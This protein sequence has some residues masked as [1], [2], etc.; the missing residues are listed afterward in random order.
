M[1]VK[2][3]GVQVLSTQG[4]GAG[5]VSGVAV[6]FATF[7]GRQGL[8]KPT[9]LTQKLPVSTSLCPVG[10]SYL[11]SINAT[12]M[13]NR[14]E[15]GFTTI[16][17]DTIPYAEEYDLSFIESYLFLSYLFIPFIG[18]LISVCVGVIVSLLSGEWQIQLKRKFITF[19]NLCL[20]PLYRGVESSAPCGKIYN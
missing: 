16:Q 8:G 19:S 2:Y 12:S 3:S 4:A 6:S 14:N 18:L 1:T 10:C 20:M 15:M 7:I 17:P 13:M 11:D 5:F 9:Y